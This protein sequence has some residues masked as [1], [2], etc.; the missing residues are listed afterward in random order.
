[1]TAEFAERN[2]F[3]LLKTFDAAM[4]T[5]GVDSDT[6]RRIVN[7]LLYGNPNGD[8]TAMLPIDFE[9]PHRGPEET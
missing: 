1:M 5:E 2:L 6:R 4:A 8:S 7:G 3:D 9:S